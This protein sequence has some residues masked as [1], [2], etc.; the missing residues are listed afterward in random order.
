MSKKYVLLGTYTLIFVFL[1][2][3]GGPTLN[4]FLNEPLGVNLKKFRIKDENILRLT[5]R[6]ISPDEQLLNL[7]ERVKFSLLSPSEEWVK[8]TFAK[9]PWVSSL[10][11]VSSDGKVLKN[12]T[13]NTPRPLTDG[14]FFVEAKSKN[15]GMVSF[16]DESAP[17]NQM[18]TGITHYQNGVF[19]G[20]LVVGFNFTDLLASV[21]AQ[22]DLAIVDVSGNISSLSENIFLPLKTVTINWEELAREE[23]FGKIITKE[24]TYSWFSFYIGESVFFYVIADV[25]QNKQ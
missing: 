7:L 8:D 17:S 9:Y 14:T 11:T 20:A 10:S 21:N 5:E 12:Y 4:E 18:F 19:S 24:T 1:T 25:P 16:L 13:Q 6:I 3:C 2:A 23:V 22:K 15:L